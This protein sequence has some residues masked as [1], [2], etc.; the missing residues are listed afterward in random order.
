MSYSSFDALK[1]FDRQS[2]SDYDL[3]ADNP[4]WYRATNKEILPTRNQ[5]REQFAGHAPLE[6]HPSLVFGTLTTI[7]GRRINVR[8]RSSSRKSKIKHSPHDSRQ[9]SSSRCGINKPGW[10]TEHYW[11]IP[12]TFCIEENLICREPI[13]S[14][15]LR[16]LATLENGS[17]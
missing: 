2:L 17:K 11:S 12:E 10:L 9:C 1:F 7:P 6:N 4:R 16:T 5:F 8:I 3:Y 13:D 14:P 15:L